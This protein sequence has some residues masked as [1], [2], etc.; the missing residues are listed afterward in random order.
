MFPPAHR[1]RTTTRTVIHQVSHFL[2]TLILR[3][4]FSES[5]MVDL[6]GEWEVEGSVDDYDY[7]EDSDLEE[8][9]EEKM[10]IAPLGNGR[11]RQTIAPRRMG[12]ICQPK[13]IAYKTF[14]GLLG[15][16]YTQ[17]LTL[18]PLKSTQ[19]TKKGKGATS[20]LNSPKSMYRLADMIDLPALKK[21]CLQAIRSGLTTDNIYT[22]LFSK[23][24]SLYPEV[25]EA[26][27]GFAVDHWAESENQ[28]GV[29]IARCIAG[30]YPHSTFAMTSLLAR[31]GPCTVSPSAS[32]SPGPLKST[33][34]FTSH[35]A[36]ASVS[37]IEWH[38]PVG[39]FPAPSTLP[40]TFSTRSLGRR[41][42]RNGRN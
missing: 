17:E 3:D 22:E 39:V 34:D 5:Q 14:K 7:H 6:D 2:D 21:T 28:R 25:L 9:E 38:P 18:A 10:N 29:A 11:E 23:F 20:D 24:A 31:L 37:P 32:F 13:N 40:P 41:G 4:G 36:V 35:D 19:D 33:E 16:L 30:D 42:G 8:L 12:R 26:E 15:Y 1:L 27:L